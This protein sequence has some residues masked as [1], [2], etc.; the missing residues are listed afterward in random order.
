MIFASVLSIASVAIAAASGSAPDGCDPLVPQY[1]MLPFPNDFWRI[2]TENGYRLN[3]TENTFPI[4]DNGKKFDPNYGGWNELHGFPL[5]PAITAYFPGMDESSIESCARWWN[6]DKSIAADS[7]TVL[8]DTVT[9]KA[10][11]HWVELDH[12]SN[13]SE[14]SG[15]HALL[16]W[17]A[18]SLEFNRRYVIG[19]KN[20]KSSR[21]TPIPLSDAFRAFRD[22]EALSS[23]DEFTRQRADH[24][25]DIFAQ[26]QR[27]GV[28][29][30]DLMLA[31]DF[32]TNDK[33]DVTGR[34]VA[35]RDDA[36]QRLGADGPEYMIHSV[37]YDTHELVAKQIKGQFLMP[38]YL[39]LT[40]PPRQPALFLT[41]T[42]YLYSRASSGTTSRSLFPRLWRRPPA[43]L[44]CCSTATASSAATA[45]W[46]TAPPRTCTKMR[47]TTAM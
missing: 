37:E 45:R 8:L 16:I 1:C 7:P 2:K 9:M 22:K 33:E 24:F 39:T 31:W 32:T 3:F 28:Q 10:V 11:P 43:R 46:S 21:G 42:T 29:R 12:S 38:T 23:D 36:R 13:K 26:L 18:T 44:A 34:M 25:E 35:A 20:M 40:S 47:R 4:D 15:K 27:A 41:R 30:R 6:M 5:M 14:V 19:I 17:P